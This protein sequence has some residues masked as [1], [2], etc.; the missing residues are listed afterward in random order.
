MAAMRKWIKGRAGA[1]V[2]ARALMAVS[3]GVLLV[4][5]A[6]GWASTR[7]PLNRTVPEHV[8]AAGRAP[9]PQPA[10]P[11]PSATSEFPGMG[12][13]LGGTCFAPGEPVIAVGQRYVL[14]TVNSAATV[15]RKSGAEVAQFPFS[16]FWGAGTTLC[17]DPRA[18]YI[19]SVERFAISCTDITNP[20]GPMRFA[21]SKTSNPA[22]GW[23]RYAAPNT[24]FL[25]QDKIVASSDKFIIAGNAGEAE[26]MY[27]YNLS[28]V[29][30]GIATPSLV[31]LTARK[32]NVYQAAVEQTPTSNAYFASSYPGS[33]LYL[34]TVSGTPAAG[35]VALKEMAVPSSDYP[36][37]HEPQVP[38]GAIGGHALDGRIYDAVFEVETSDGK[39]VIAYSSARECGTRTCVTNARIDLSGAKPVLSSNVLI[40]EPGSDYSYGAV[41]LNAAG[42]AFEV[43][44][45]SSS[46]SD[47]GVGVLG[48]GFDVP[49][50]PA[51]GTSTCGES[52]PPCDERWGDYLGAAIDPS[53]PSSVW[54]SGLY[55][56]ANGAFGWGTV[57]AKVS[58]S[59]FSLPSVSTGAATSVTATAANI[60]GSVNP[61]GLPTTY[62]VDYGLTTG[63]DA[64]TAEQAA[65]SGTTAIPVTAALGGLDPN[66]PY[67]YR[68]VASASTGS[69]VGADKTFKTKAPKITAV[70]FT[71][72]P[73]EPTI[74][75]SGSNFGAL[76]PPNPSTPVSCV[77][78]DTSFDYGSSGLSFGET[79]RGW[80]AGQSGDCIGLLV[81]SYTSTQIVYRLGKA[82][83]EYPPITAGD[84]YAVT[85]WGKTH[86]GTVAF[87]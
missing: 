23:F 19:S 28:D 45:R 59:S 12:P 10:A 69:A 87:S 51:V 7:A 15:Y 3:L 22:G 86:T 24:R 75:I 4:A 14:E 58:A 2:G 72:T 25:D 5:P 65:G 77:P 17:V 53:E 57:I 33:K 68:V 82:Y 47:P 41:G 43:Y 85:V 6:R 64:S 32:S 30:A 21:I 34:A 13:C 29:I 70:T 36:A 9:A 8:P 61:S 44:S 55:Q 11:V 31:A 62:H 63:Y 50:Q 46:S 49:L 76:A 54:V 74:T 37:P 78:E 40:G 27:V 79:T 60:A 35:D 66:T 56:A 80:G 83:G 84:E 52:S 42:T 26:Q 20:N 39:P 1:G 67:H 38:G 81:S 18:L 48:P 71:G 16:S 73:A